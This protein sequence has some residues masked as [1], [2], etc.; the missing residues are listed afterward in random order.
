MSSRIVRQCLPIY[1]TG[2]PGWISDTLRAAGLVVDEM[3]TVKWHA[4]LRQS[5]EPREM[6]VLFDSRTAFSRDNAAAFQ[7]RGCCLID[8]AALLRS[9]QGSRAEGPGPEVGGQEELGRE[10]SINHQPSTMNPSD[11]R[12]S[13]L[14]SQRFLSRPTPAPRRLR[15]LER[16]KQQIE[17]A[18]F[19]WA[20]V[21]DFPYPFQSALVDGRSDR[22][23]PVPRPAEAGHYEP[24]ARRTVLFPA[25]ARERRDPDFDAFGSGSE[26]APGRADVD[27]LYAHYVAGH[28]LC[29][30]PELSPADAA[31]LD[32]ALE[33]GLFPLLWR[34]T[35]AEYANWRRQRR[36]FRFEIYERLR[37]Y[38]IRYEQLPV[39]HRPAV[40]LWRG[41]HFA[42]VP[43]QRSRQVID[44]GKVVFQSSS[45]RH[46]AGLAGLH[47][48][49]EPH[50]ALLTAAARAV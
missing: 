26:P 16:A 25:V 39:H 30:A 23:Q 41:G 32:S 38:E 31:I 43:L 20:R 50:T 44:A 22:L 48:D 42:V 29:V 1:S 2:I 28:A 27:S 6:L 19:L 45:R 34:T 13:P 15:V 49:L 47:A 12:P 9:G 40:E 17:S 33:S 46:P 4:A 10:S 7:Q 3:T 11:S 21:A 35:P 5:D 14:G 37:R 36:E 24:A 18:G 8:V